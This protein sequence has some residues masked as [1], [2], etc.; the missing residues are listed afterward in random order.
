MSDPEGIKQENRGL[1]GLNSVWKAI[2]IYVW[3]FS[4]NIIVSIHS[5][6]SVSL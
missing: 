5:T 1:N 6:T 3:L 4:E 2:H